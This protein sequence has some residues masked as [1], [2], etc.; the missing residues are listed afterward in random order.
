MAKDGPN[1]VVRIQAVCQ[2]G[3]K[4][5]IIAPVTK[6]SGS[7]RS[8]NFRGTQFCCDIAS[9]D[10]QGKILVS[11]WA[12]AESDVVG[13]GIELDGALIGEA[14]IGLPRPD[15]GNRFPRIASARKAGFQFS[16]ALGIELKGEHTLTVRVR[17]GSGS[18]Q[19]I[20]LPVRTQAVEHADYPVQATTE[21]IRFDLDLPLLSGEKARDPVRT[22]LSIV[23]WAL[24]S[25]GIN[26]I[27]VT[28]DD[29]SFGHAYYG[30]RREDVASAFPEREDAL[31]CGFAL[32]VA[33]RDIGVG[34]HAVSVVIHSVDGD[35]VERS[36]SIV[37]EKSDEISQFEMIRPKLGQAE[38]D[39]GLSLVDRV[40]HCFF[41]IKLGLNDFSD[42]T[43]A[44][45]LQ[46]LA[47]LRA[48]AYPNWRAIIDAPPHANPAHFMERLT[49]DAEWP[50]SK[51]SL[52]A[53][54]AERGQKT[55]NLLVC[56]LRAGDRLG[57]DA[58]LEFAIHA[59]LNPDDDFIYSDDRRRNPTTG[60]DDPFFKP[61][62]SPELLLAF[63]YIGRS[64]C[65]RGAALDAAE[66]SLR[67][68]RANSDYATVLR[69]TESARAIGHLPRLLLHEVDDDADAEANYQAVAD[70]VGRRG[71]AATVGTRSREGAL[72]GSL[73]RRSRQVAFPL[74]SRPSPRAG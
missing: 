10:S 28:I 52:G 31:L 64:W 66:L 58:L 40:G 36:F 34:E 46:T 65:A 17:E 62:W 20:P 50:A 54:T 11:G 5:Q 35:T 38:I 73:G 19:E 63:N 47:S 53:G 61:D 9:V 26:Y 25:G 3:L 43:L 2:G 6:R 23:G 74:S 18:E 4:R 14:K 12:V 8:S 69:L 72:F 49:A 7:R 1:P 42:T 51:V 60:A 45:A 39:H 15:V 24:A 57:A 68:I 22:T 71:F 37:C 70:A 27:D 59:A 16:H 13:V 67:E 33:A 56:I 29:Q 55:E 21:G 30:M 32:L 48:Q 41:T 44:N